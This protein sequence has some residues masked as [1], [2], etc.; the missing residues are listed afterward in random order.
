[1]KQLLTRLTLA[2]GLAA[3]V[4]LAQ[5]DDQVARGAYLARA[6][7]C[8]A[9]H[10][11]P[12]GAPYAGGLPIVSPFGT[13]YGTNITPSKEH[14]IGLYSDDEFFA[15]LDLIIGVGK[16]HRRSKADRQGQA[17]QKKLHA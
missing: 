13:I 9:C 8:M 6:A 12:G 2:V 1:M 3:P 5:A 7:D 10:T 16:Q 15:A 14:G 11:A 4:L 17:A